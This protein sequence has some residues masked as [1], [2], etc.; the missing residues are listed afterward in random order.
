MCYRKGRCI[1]IGNDVASPSVV[2]AQYI[3]VLKDVQYEVRDVVNHRQCDQMATLFL[4]IGPF[5]KLENM[6]NTIN[7]LPKWIENFAKAVA[8]N[9]IFYK[10]WI[11]LPN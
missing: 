5:A 8:K 2:S 1:L 4:N 9:L 3:L 7:V 6:R 10:N 11:F